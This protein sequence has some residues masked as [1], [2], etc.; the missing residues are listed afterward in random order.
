MKSLY[1]IIAFLLWICAAVADPITEKR[2]N[3][4]WVKSA[5]VAEAEEIFSEY[6]FEDFNRIKMK[7]PRIYFLHL[8]KDWKEVADSEDKN[9]TFIKIILPLALKVNE[10]V[11]AER[12]QI[13][14]LRKKF[15]ET[16]V[17]NEEEQ[18]IL[19]DKSKKYDVFTRFKGNKRFKILLTQLLE[20]VDAVPPSLIV[21][22]AGIYSDWGNSRLAR[23]ANSLYLTEIWYDTK[24]LKPLDDENAEYRYKIY[25]SLEESIEDHI[26]KINS[27]I[28]YAYLR[29][30][31]KY[32]REIDR[33]LYGSQWAAL[34]PLDSNLKNIAGLIDYTFT[35]YE[36][37]KTDY[38]SELED[39]K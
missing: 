10:K 39:I 24:G 8:P 20:K 27:H 25:S 19:E 5:T 16:G 14:S 31:R 7:F 28:N 1:P 33:P 15:N 37:Q 26:L 18:K 22:T 17:L 21:S 11:L 12:A 23:L 35:Y 30:A 2:D 3:A 9:R 38:L 29:K 36:L 4:L 34:M 32:A 13:E 6:K